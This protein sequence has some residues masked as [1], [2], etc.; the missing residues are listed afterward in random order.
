V[1]VHSLLRVVCCIRLRW[2]FSR[3]AWACLR[4]HV[5]VV[6]WCFTYCVLCML[7]L[8]V[9]FGYCVVWAI[10]LCVVAPLIGW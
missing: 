5:V 4:W 1:L 2:C 7:L 10:S 8:C 9:V 3:V 6:R